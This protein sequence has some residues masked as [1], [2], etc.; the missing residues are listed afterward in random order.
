M[1]ADTD[2]HGEEG[3]AFSGVDTHI[4]KMVVIEYPVVHP[5]AGSAVIVDFLIYVC[6]TGDRGIEADVPFRF[7]VNASTIRRGGAF[8]PTGAGTHFAAGERAA[9]F[10]GM[11]LSAVSPVDH[12]ETGHA[13]R[14]AVLI[15]GDGIRD[16]IRAAPV[17][18]KINKRPDIPFLTQHISGVIV[19]G[20]VQADIPDG[21]IRVNG[22][23]FPERDNGT[24]AVMTSGIQKADM[25]GQVKPDMCIVCTEHVKGVA[26]IKNLLIAVPSPMGVGVGEMAFAGTSGNTMFQTIADLISIRG[27][28]GMDAGTVSGKGDAVL[29]DESVLKG[30]EDGGKAK[31]LLEPFL[32]MKGE[33]SVLQGV[34]AHLIRNAGMLIG[35]LL[36]SA[37]FFE[38]LSVSILR[39]KILSA[40]SLGVFGLCPEPV[41]KIK[42]RTKRRKGIRGAAGEGCKQAVGLQL[43]DP[44]SQAG[45]AEQY[46]KDKGADDL[47]LVFGRPAERGIEGGKVFQYRIQVQKAELFPDRVEFKPEPCALGRIKMYFCLMQEIQILLMGL[48]VNQHV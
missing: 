13:Q 47:R 44:D 10:S 41:H 2:D 11:F 16:G 8:F 15:D 6:P 17:G 42:V 39:E 48:P 9:P 35:K 28:M 3:I 43:P 20:G 5:F 37:G 23:K 38:R 45:E 31:N 34:R 24:D 14:G 26:E 18:I 1:D 12:A 30:W 25:Q 36:P 29:R 21:N 27:R 22:F 33:L 4:M 19:M 46:H 40:G 32:I 7:C